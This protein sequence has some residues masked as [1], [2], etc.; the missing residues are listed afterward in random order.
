M[1][2]ADPTLAPDWLTAPH[3]DVPHGF[4]TRAGGVSRGPY[5][6]LNL[7]ATT[8]DEA[9]AVAANRAAFLAHFGA[10][11]DTTCLLH[12]V[13]SDRVV[14]ARPS[15]G[16]LEADAA[17]TD[18][19]ALLLVVAT[20]DCYPLLYHDPVRGAVGAAHCGWRGTVAGLAGR[21]LERLRR[22]YGSDPA[23][24]RVAI[25]PGICGRCYQVGDEVV[26]AF[27]TA[28]FPDEIA[29]PDEDGRWRLDLVRANR[30]VLER[31]GARPERVVALEACTPEEP[32]RFYSHRRDRGV[33]GRHWSAIRLAA[34]GAR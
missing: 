32:G 33:T 6:G 11:P 27:R 29:R 14:T 8:G 17:V 24:V 13:H 18:D 30:L 3:L 20:A 23:D 9:A 15:W 26:A 34:P 16:D 21:V 2:A 1:S 12:Q 4:A 5:R 31:A 25:G 10:A 19:P 7:G 22:D 28:G